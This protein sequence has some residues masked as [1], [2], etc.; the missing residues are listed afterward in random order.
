MKHTICYKNT[1]LSRF[2]VIGLSLLII[3][4]SVNGQQ[5]TNNQQTNQNTNNV[6]Y[7]DLV[8]ELDA[9]YK[10]DKDVDDND[11]LA[12]T[13]DLKS[14]VFE[15]QI[16]NELL[17]GS[18]V[19]SASDFDDLIGSGA[20]LWMIKW[21]YLDSDSVNE[22]IQTFL[23]AL[24]HNTYLI[25][26]LSVLFVLGMLRN[27]LNAFIEKGRLFDVKDLVHRASLMGFYFSYPLIMYWFST[28]ING[29]AFHVQEAIGDAKKDNIYVQ[30]SMMIKDSEFDLSRTEQALLMK[31]VRENNTNDDPYY[32]IATFSHY[33]EKVQKKEDDLGLW[34]KAEYYLQ[35]I[36][37]SIQALRMSLHESLIMFLGSIIKGVILLLLFALDKIFLCTGVLSIISSQIPL[38]RDKWATN[39]TRWLTVKC[40]LI[41]FLI[42]DGIVAMIQNNDILISNYGHD[43]V[44]PLFGTVISLMAIVCYIFSFTITSSWIG[45]ESAGKTLSNMGAIA[46]MIAGKAVASKLLGK[47]ATNG[48][49]QYGNK[50]DPAMNI[51]HNTKGQEATNNLDR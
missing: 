12:K 29:V 26:V 34:D 41:T 36:W 40:T 1:V 16:S 18:L 8:D 42:I 4:S 30:F 5:Q 13:K 51:A 11:I 28:L 3:S 45:S 31:Y 49:D 48:L 33:K 15:E 37:N 44:N 39:L 7:K 21:L 46:T 22:S 17:G 10:L 35:K 20:T 47:S 38:F 32:N 27:M 9:I 19:N 6:S 14:G 24:V 23:W 2:V 25:K 50:L 43:M